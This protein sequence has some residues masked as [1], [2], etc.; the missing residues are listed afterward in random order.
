MNR[1]PSM[2]DGMPEAQSIAYPED[3]GIPD[4]PFDQPFE[5]PQPVRRA[6]PRAERPVQ[7]APV[8]PETSQPPV[9]T[10]ENGSQFEPPA[11]PEIPD[12]LRVAQQN[13]PRLGGADT[14][15]RFDFQRRRCRFREPDCL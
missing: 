10:T 9:T 1:L 3:Y 8:Q 13:Q 7:E 2:A 12:W 4:N 11:A 15:L 14:R 5:P 6:R